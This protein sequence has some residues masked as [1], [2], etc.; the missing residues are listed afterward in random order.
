MLCLA[1]QSCPTLCNPMV[2]SP[3]GS[4]IHGDS[5][6]KNTGE[7]CSGLPCPPVGD[8]PNPGIEPRSPSFAGR[9]SAS[10]VAQMVKCPLAMRETWV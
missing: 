10:L 2:C 9:F 6:G 5:P 4:S 3:P 7:Y 1:G 8:L